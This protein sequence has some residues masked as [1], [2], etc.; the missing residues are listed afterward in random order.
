MGDEEEGTN[1]VHTKKKASEHGVTDEHDS[2]VYNIESNL[3]PIA[4]FQS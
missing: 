2:M 3:C 4:H 1:C